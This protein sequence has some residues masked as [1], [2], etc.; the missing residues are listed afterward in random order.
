MEKYSHRGVIAPKEVIPKI[1]QRDFSFLDEQT[2]GFHFSYHGTF[3]FH[4]V[5]IFASIPLYYTFENNKL[6]VS[7]DF[8]ELLPHLPKVTFDSI[9]Y[10]TSGGNGK[11]YQ[12][13]H[14]TPFT[15]I[16]RIP[17]GHYLIFENNELQVIE[18]WSFLK[19][20]N[21]AFT[22]TY[23]EACIKM[24][25]LIKQAVKRAHEYD[26]NAA[27]HLS[28]GFDSGSITALIC[29]LSNEQRLAF[30]YHKEGSP[31]LHDTYE[32]GFIGKYQ[33]EYPH[34]QVVLPNINNYSEADTKHWLSFHSIEYSTLQKGTARKETN[35][36]NWFRR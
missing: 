28:G 18:Y 3:D 32:S 16:L 7:E 8:E 33:K 5:D 6:H 35:Y 34:L 25:Q 31:K 14:R 30:G 20:K 10:F 19:L 12:K 22:G 9:G 23:D 1:K 29:Q 13:T 4:A 11:S 17:A 27:L 26:P 15:E 36:F 2:L 21:K 24:G